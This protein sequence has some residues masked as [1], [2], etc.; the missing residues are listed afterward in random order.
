MCNKRFSGDLYAPSWLEWALH[1]VYFYF[2]QVDG[3][4][5]LTCCTESDENLI[6]IG[7]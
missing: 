6:L 3:L 2:M 4:L 5:Q 7:F 1:T